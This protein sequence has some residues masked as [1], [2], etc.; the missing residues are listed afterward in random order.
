MVHKYVGQF[1]KSDWD[2]TMMRT[3]WSP[4]STY[5]YFWYLFVEL[6]VVTPVEW[7]NFVSLVPAAKKSK[8]GPIFSINICVMYIL[9]V[10]KQ[11]TGQKTG[12][13][14]PKRMFFSSPPTSWL[15][16]D[17]FW[18][19]QNPFDSIITYSNWFMRQSGWTE[20]V[21]GKVD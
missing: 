11:K 14:S 1:V 21:V 13:N 2:D 7:R 18:P 12:K 9:S 19:G 6:A 5:S 17:R 16:L 4:N 20:F 8:L 10:E 15:S 3:G